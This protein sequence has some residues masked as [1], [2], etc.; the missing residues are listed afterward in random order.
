VTSN[1]TTNSRINSIENSL[2]KSNKDP[3]AKPVNIKKGR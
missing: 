3:G 1:V 2:F